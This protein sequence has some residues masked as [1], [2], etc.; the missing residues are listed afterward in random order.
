MDANNTVKSQIEF[1]DNDVRIAGVNFNVANR[2]AT[3][4]AAGIVTQGP[5][6]NPG[7]CDGVF[8]PDIYQVESIDEHA[9]YMWKNKHLWAVGATGPDKPFNLTEKTAGILHELEKAHIY[10]EQLH[11]RLQAVE[12]ATAH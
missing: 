8:R 9:A 1:R 5:T 11:K 10:I 3:I 2:W 7:P 4:S 6:C 12:K